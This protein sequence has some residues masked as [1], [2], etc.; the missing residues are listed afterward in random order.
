M[1]KSKHSLAVAAG[2]VVCLIVVWFAGSIQGKSYE[3]KPEISLPEYRT[4]AARAIDAYER[5]MD[6]FMNLTERSL[7]GINT[8]VR[9]IT[10][11][12]V[13]IDRKLSELSTRMARIEKALGIE[14]KQ[15]EKP[16]EEPSE[17]ET[18]N[19]ADKPGL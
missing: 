9:G 14:I 13:S 19:R 2:L 4:D 8:D 7:R 3:V 10:E 17:A 6:R 11:Q 5:L 18:H 16:V 15:T 1:K 12:L